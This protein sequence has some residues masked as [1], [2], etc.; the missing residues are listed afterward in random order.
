MVAIKVNVD[1][2]HRSPP[3]IHRALPQAN[4]RLRAFYVLAGDR[5]EVY[6]TCNALYKSHTQGADESGSELYSSRRPPSRRP[7][8]FRTPRPNSSERLRGISPC[9]TDKRESRHKRVDRTGQR[10]SHSSL[11][12]DQLNRGSR[13]AFSILPLI[14]APS[15]KPNTV[16]RNKVTTS[17]SRGE[18]LSNHK[19]PPLSGIPTRVRMRTRELTET[20]CLYI[21]FLPSSSIWVSVPQRGAGA[22]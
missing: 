2:S 22:D 16:N 19:A 3:M 9:P 21:A 14:P 11:P 8:K 4:R 7:N 17:W 1:P 5:Y 13:P 12:A 20:T 10:T 18:S 15:S 6:S